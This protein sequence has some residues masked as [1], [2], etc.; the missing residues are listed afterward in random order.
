M[1]SYLWKVFGALL[2]GLP[3]G[4]YTAFVAECFWNWFAVPALHVS[5]ISFLQWLGLYWLIGLLKGRSSDEE[6]NRWISLM[7][8]LELCIPEEKQQAL[9]DLRETEADL[10]L[11][12]AFWL[13]S[14][15]VAGNTFTLTL[16]FI[17]HL[18]VS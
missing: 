14:A 7:S 18:I 12:K 16:G 3:V 10:D 5:E 6:D 15:Q 11:L 13:V 9:K 4:I 2:V 1:K 17:L 8:V